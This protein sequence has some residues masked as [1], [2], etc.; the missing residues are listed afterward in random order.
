[1][2]ALDITLIGVAWG[3]SIFIE[4]INAEGKTFY[5]LIDSND[6]T[7]QKSSFIFLKKYFERK[8]IDTDRN[9]PLFDFVLLS[10]AHSDHG[11]GLKEIM[12]KFGTKYFYYSKSLQWAALSTLISFANRSP[13][14]EHH[15]ALNSGKTLPPL[16]D[17][18]LKVLWPD[19]DTIPDDNEN[20]NSIILLIRLNN[21]AVLLTGDSEKD[22]WAQIAGRIP[23]DIQVF[24]VPHHGS[25]NGTFG[26]SG[27]PC[28]LDKI[29]QGTLL[30]I[31]SHIKPYGHPHKKVLD[32]F[33]SKNYKY[34]RTDT[35][36]HVTFRI[37]DV[38]VR[39]KYSHY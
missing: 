17:A 4:S 10:H 36:Y 16:G 28:W 27:D 13:G 14:V 6:T 33:D 21:V 8:G 9:K 15:E 35:D 32:L 5:A 19:H 34:F 2:I 25:V 26:D 31:S 1:M 39:T 23:P 18:F 22:V 30:A 29:S 3:D 38:N 20:N 11:Q 24:K 12:M 7:S 37:E